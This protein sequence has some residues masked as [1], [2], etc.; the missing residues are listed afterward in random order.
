MIPFHSL[1]VSSKQDYL[2]SI[3]F[4]SFPFF[5]FKISNQGYLIPFHFI[6]F[7][8]FPL[9][10]YIP[11]LSIPLWSF[12]SIPLWTLKQNLIFMINFTVNLISGLG[13]K[14]SEYEY[15]IITH[16]QHTRWK[17]IYNHLFHKNF[18]PERIRG[19][20]PFAPYWAKDLA[21]CPRLQT[22]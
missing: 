12:H 22:I 8:S 15:L 7:H 18:V 9:L 16:L 11:F 6:L 5:Y 21:I 13:H 14:R 1:H 3:H 4:H 10:K 17:K 20:Y 2:H 19:I